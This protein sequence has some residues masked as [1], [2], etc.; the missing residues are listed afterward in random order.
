MFKGFSS[1]D[2]MQKELKYVLTMV[3]EKKKHVDIVKTPDI[4]VDQHSTQREVQ[5]WLTAKGF[6]D[7]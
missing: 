7:K 3:R 6:S 4:F 2:Q 1:Q 5:K